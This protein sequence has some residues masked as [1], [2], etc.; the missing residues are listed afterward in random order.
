MP[1]A[2]QRSTAKIECNAALVVTFAGSEKGA[3]FMR[4]VLPVRSVILI[5]VALGVWDGR[6]AV[7]AQYY[8]STSAGYGSTQGSGSRKA[9]VPR[10]GK[11]ACSAAAV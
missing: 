6:T 10:P 7:Q 11:W 5:W 8:G 9:T 2:A 3:L 4:L 1:S